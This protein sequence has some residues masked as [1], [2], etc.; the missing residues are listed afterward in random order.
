M[1]LWAQRVLGRV[2][3]LRED[4]TTV[5]LLMFA[6]S[7]LAMTA[8]NILRPITGSNFIDQL[9][10]DNQ[11]FVQLAV[12][13][14]IGV[15]MHWY[16]NVVRKLPRRRVI[17]ITQL[18][19]VAILVAFWGLQRTGAV[20][21]TVGLYSL[22]LLLG[23]FLISQFWTLAN[24]IYDARQAKRLFGFIGGGA[25]LGGAV[26]A[27]ILR[28]LVYQVGSNNMLLVSAAFLGLC[29]VI[30]DRI[31]RYQPTLASDGY[32][33]QGVGGRE[34]FRLLAESD[35][36]KI[37]ALV[38]GCAAAGGSIVQQQLSMAAEATGGDADRMTAFLAEVTG[39]M[40][41][42][43]FIV[44]V[45]LT[46]RIH[47]SMGLAF[48]MLLLPM[49]MGSSAIVVIM[50]GALWA[51][52]LARILEAT[53][54][55]TVDKTTREVLFLP[56]PVELK[57]RAKPFI[58]VTAD[59]FA[60]ALAAVLLLVLIKPWGLGLDWRR[61]SYA[62]LAMTGIW[63]GIVFVAWREYRRAFRDSIG[64]RA[65]APGTIRTDLADTATIETLVEE[66]SHP[67]E[68]AVLY[69]I[70]MLDALDKRH[71]VTPL[72][73]QHQSPRVRARTLRALAL[74][75]S[76]AAGRWLPT[77]T[78]MVQDED[79][80]VRAAALRALAELEHEDAAVLMRRHLGDAEPRVV[81]TSAISLANSGRPDD[82]SAAEAA[83][84]HIITDVRDTAAAGRAEAATALAHI[85]D[86][87]FR[88]LLVPLL[89]DRDPVVVQKAIRS[90]REMGASDG[91]FIP[92]LLSLLGHR[93]LK[94]SAREALV[95]YGETIIGALA[96]ALRDQR[97]HVWIRRHIPATLAEL[98]TQGS[99]DALVGA[100]DDPDGF[101][102]Y[103]AIAAIE[104]I[105]RDHPAIVC[106]R[107][108]LEAQVVRES[109]RYYNG[110]TLQHNLL[111]HAPEAADS[112]LARALQ[113][114]LHRT[115]DRIYRLLGLLYHVDDVAAAR[116]TIE[117]GESR[118]RAAAVEYLDN[119]LGGVVRKR[120]MPILDDSPLTEKVR[121]A[122]AVLK[123]RPRDLEDTL[124][125]LVHEDDPVIA[126]AAIHFVGQRHVWALSDDLE[127]V[128]SHRS[129]NRIIGEAVS[130]A[131]AARHANGGSLTASVDSL[132]IVELA[133]RVRVISL[134]AAL[135][136]DEL[137][138]IAEAGEEIR[139]PAG[140][141]LCHA[142]TPAG[143]V[144]FLLEGGARTIDGPAPETEVV[145]P[146]VIGFEDVLQGTVLRSTV[147]AIE[148]T[149][150][151]RIAADDFM[152]M[153]S[154]N[155]LLAQ[156]LFTLLLADDRP[157][158]PFSPPPRVL[159]DHESPGAVHAARLLRQDPL[160]SRA[161]AAQ[162]LA[163]TAVA[164]EVPLK[165][166]TVLFDVGTPPAVYQIVQGEVVLEHSGTNMAVAPPGATIG[167]ADTLAGTT[168]GW[169]ATVTK[170]GRALRLE[171]DELFS[172]L[173]DHVDLMQG[174]FSGVLAL[175]ET[176]TKVAELS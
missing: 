53:L 122:N 131:L 62:S 160:L 58:D 75:R 145:P 74:S 166:G 64:S 25:S 170:D 17:P 85:D 132:P 117:R 8:H 174:L 60:K 97:E 143:D 59:R 142:A 15:L 14:L 148:P 21:V 112:L 91:L 18:A 155:V 79:V 76:P 90:A 34:A 43:G 61:L 45:A 101:L 35:H 120:V 52:Q 172:V 146:A 94:A 47:R 164:P 51:P 127:Y 93:A 73:L 158:L 22:G 103:K 83:L 128:A 141:E 102:R 125:Q 108:V 163:L 152:T 82:V 86:P 84:R 118:R 78:R 168:S 56:L 7:F 10:A 113:D 99:M 92:G 57:H 139:H 55:Y 80:N 67:D 19:I 88:A 124:A 115:I 3:S 130:W 123:S 159:A 175:R 110:L 49:A 40:S 104:K 109:S 36:L 31:L 169:R 100:L 98:G 136:V 157:R 27:M 129:D 119:L 28:V 135:S 71:L 33:E 38:I 153:V 12:G 87:R 121:Y 107:A 137:F 6:Y 11:P 13:L 156:S 26:G 95:G 140:R 134:F 70:E 89:Y 23:V 66:L 5:A 54:R 171:R 126:A 29:V 114:K 16:S 133:N 151:F 106:P 50:S 1:N 154:D 77:V 4:E 48:A 173:A 44:Q 39:W 37:M 32:E 111:R 162:L 147:C 116:Y 46:S 30:V 2:V 63:V 72:L 176:E 9:G 144:L 96:Y 41:I 65:I 165:A 81:V 20:W 150:C 42:G 138:R 161:S 105:R 149:V 68:P 24:E 69:A 167:V